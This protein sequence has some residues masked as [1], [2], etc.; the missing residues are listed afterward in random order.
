MKLW[1][2]CPEVETLNPCHAVVSPGAIQMRKMREIYRRAQA[3]HF[4]PEGVFLWA[5]RVVPSLRAACASFSIPSPVRAAACRYDAMCHTGE[6]TWA[7]IASF[8]AS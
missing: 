4:F 7:C 6:M 2:I 5:S 1:S 8:R 3:F